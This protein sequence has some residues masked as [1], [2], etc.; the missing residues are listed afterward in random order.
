MEFKSGSD[1]DLTDQHREYLEHSFRY[2]SEQ[3]VLPIL[4]KS[5]MKNLEEFILV[6]VKVRRVAHR[7]EETRYIT[8]ASAPR[9]LPD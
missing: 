5:E 8:L 2:Q 9:L 6:P 3:E 7:F 4:Y 1:A